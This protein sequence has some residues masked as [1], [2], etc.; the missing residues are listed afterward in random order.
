MSATKII[1]A[2]DLATKTGWALWPCSGT[3]RLPGADMQPGEREKA[4]WNYL[5]A[6]HDNPGFDVVAVEDSSAFSRG[7]F[8]AA[9][10]GNLRG[11]VSLFCAQHGITQLTCT[12]N[13]L[14]AF[15]GNGRAKKPEMIAAYLR[16]F[17]E[18]HQPRDDNE[19]DALWLL[20]WAR[21]KLAGRIADPVKTTRQ[22]KPK[23]QPRTLFTK[24]RK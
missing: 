19:C 8:A 12:P 15:A 5:T 4:L 17:P 24:G 7:G 3:W 9:V 2:L 21:A 1:L 11:V 10:Q 6:A 13:Q 22:H 16:H 23:K 18:R 14:K 20:E